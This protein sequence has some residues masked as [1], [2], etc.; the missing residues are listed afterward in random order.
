MSSF[1]TYNDYETRL[2][3][4]ILKLLT[5]DN[6]Y[7]LNNAETEAVG[8]ITDRLADKYS[9]SAEFAKSGSA[10]NSSLV[11]W[12]LAIAIYTLY[13]RIAD[14]EVPERV[15][16]DYDDALEELKLIAQGKLRCTLTL[17]TDSDG[18]T[19]SRIRMGSNDPRT[20]NPFEYP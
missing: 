12:T 5:D 7:L 2:T 1:I 4:R 3:P 11:R 8:L 20:H 10:R 18:E 15:I 16:K 6:D 13:S 17:V 14:E 9:I 19:V